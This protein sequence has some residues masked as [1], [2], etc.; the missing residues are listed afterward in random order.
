MLATLA[1]VVIAA[2]TSQAPQLH[3]VPFT[4]VTITDAFWSPRQETNRTVSLKHNLDKLEQAG[5]IPNLELAAAGKREGYN[6]PVFM[7]SDLFK[8]VEAVS[9]S[10]ATHPDKDL[11]ARLD[12][13]ITKIAAAQ[14][15]DGYLNTWYQVNAPDKRFTNLRDHHELYCAGHLFEAAVAHFQA[16]GART[17]LNVATKYADLLCGTF[18]PGKREGYCG[19]PEIELALI[20]LSRI[21]DKDRSA[22]YFALAKHFI[23]T[24]GSHFFAKEHNTPLDKY[25]GEYWQD[26]V[27]IRQHTRIVGHAVRAAYLLSACTDIAAATNDTP[28]MNMVDRVWRN[29]TERNTYLTGGIGPSAHNE[30]FTVD[31]DLPN[32]SAYQETCAS[33]AMILWNHRLNLAHAHAKYADAVETALYNGALAGVSLDGTMFFYVNPLESRGGHHRRDWYGCACCPPNICR[34]LASLGSY[35]YATSGDDDNPELWINQFV[36]GSVSPEAIPGF[37]VCVTTTYP[38]DG[39]VKF[40]VDP[41]GKHHTTP[42]H[43]R[44]P[45]WCSGPVILDERPMPAEATKNGY[46]TISRTWRGPQ[47]FTMVFPMPP[48]R[49]EANPKVEADRGLRAIARGPLIYC[50]EQTDVGEW[51]IAISADSEL[52]VVDRPDMLGGI[53][54]IAGKAMVQSGTFPARELYRTAPPVKEVPFTAVPYYAWDNRTAE[55]RG[56]MQVWHP[57]ALPSPRIESLEAKAKVSISFKNWNCDPEA[58]RDGVVPAKSNVTPGSNCHWWSHKGTTEWIAYE[59]DAAVPVNSIAVFWF[60]DTGKGECRLPKAARLL[61]RQGSEWKL[62]GQVPIARDKWCELP[63]AT[64]TKALRLEV[65]MKDNFSAG[66]LEWTVE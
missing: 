14:M 41:G 17:L 61:T 8:G 51:P 58:A 54:A 22:A 21:V 64:T 48:R 28:L 32:E 35:I 24:R 36:Q 10:L 16:T 66:I 12:A 23:D 18:G 65:D 30:G 31:Y 55:G 20:K 37:K 45:S 50:V 46:L 1:H 13:I 53:M 43:I 7:D 38:W 11:S 4:Q 29:T 3:E 19:H 39:V 9:Y 44:I 59:W 57:A 34:L 25:D 27:P 63:V 15:P 56:G 60:D 47:S 42:I 6:G 2:A 26:N 40:S 52:R 5:N 49:V 33:V 62:I